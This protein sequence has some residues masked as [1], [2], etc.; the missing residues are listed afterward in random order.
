MQA[1]KRAQV[2]ATMTVNEQNVKFQV[3]TGAE[4]NTINQKYVR[5]TQVK[6]R[7]TKLKRWN[8][9]IVNSL[10]ELEL[11]VTN[12]MSDETHSVNFVVVR[13]EFQSLLDLKTVQA[14]GL[15]TIH[16]ENLIHLVAKDL[17]DLGE[18][19]LKIDKNA[20]PKVLPARNIPIAIKEQ[21]KAELD[22]LEE[23]GIIVPVSDPNEWV[24]QIV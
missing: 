5:K 18:V 16:S 6:K 22:I 1:E 14:L 9:S 13:N 21:V 7:Y 24:N 3:D 11:K 15:V 4:I 8:K 23:R 2:T 12:P 10:G 20:T 19:K 17:G